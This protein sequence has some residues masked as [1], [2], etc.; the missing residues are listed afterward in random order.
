MS[1]KSD[2]WI[3]QQAEAGMI[4]PFVGRQVRRTD[5]DSAISFGVSSYGYDMRVAS[6]WTLW[7]QPKELE[8]EGIHPVID[9]K[10]NNLH[11]F[12]NSVNADVLTIP[13][14]TFVLCRSVERF[15]IPRSVS[16]IVIGKSTYA[17][18]GLQVTCTPLEPEWEGEVTIELFNSAP[19]PLRVYANEG[20][21][22]CVFFESDD[23]C[24]VSYA[25]RK[26]KYQHQVGITYPRA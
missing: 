22:Q 19:Y 14:Q 12:L 1:I 24:L 13:P 3:C 17:R 10:E 2:A 16:V 11:Q 26:G 6:E 9:P 25:D 8:R 21:A 23:P 15:V 4:T 5:H 18:C 7:R 20:I